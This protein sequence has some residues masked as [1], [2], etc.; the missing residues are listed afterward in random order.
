MCPTSKSRPT[1]TIS[2]TTL[3]VRIDP[4]DLYVIRLITATVCDEVY[5]RHLKAI[6]TSSLNIV[7]CILFS[8]TTNEAMKVV[9]SRLF[10]SLQARQPKTTTAVS[11]DN[12]V[13]HHHEMD[14][15]SEQPTIQGL[16]NYLVSGLRKIVDV[17]GLLWLDLDDP[18]SRVLDDLAEKHGFHELSIEDCRHRLQLA[19]VD[20]YDNY[21]FFIFNTTHLFER[22]CEVKI[23]EVDLFLGK[24]FIIT[25]HYGESI[26]INEIEKRVKTKADR[27]CRPDK[28]LHAILD[29]VV[30]LYL[31]TLD[32]IG[33]TFDTVQDEVLVR[34]RVELLETM[35]GLKRGL[36][37]LRRAITSQRKLLNHIIRDESDYVS[38]DM[39]AYYKDVYDHSV[40]AMDFVETY[41]DLVAGG[42]DIYLTQMANRTN[43]IV[44][45]LTILATI[46][47]PLNLITGFFG[48]NFHYIPL[49][50]N[51]YGI[52]YTTAVLIIIPLLML[53]YF[54]YK[55]WF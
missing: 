23:K 48:M 55:K 13:Y 24:D 32:K 16:A 52:F 53:V 21:T 28:I 27:L 7:R 40:R 15:P 10:A 5:N 20:Y 11:L 12:D 31:P 36:L 29:L 33:D 2:R 25:V 22:S 17:P 19:K 45:G 38:D 51:R 26:A 54:K 6:T 43:D 39:K 30:D 35:F 46:L 4:N 18:M 1:P 50:D 37:Q 3:E 14:L 8:T 44:K 34:P 42:L 47:L 9:D 49:L 41:R